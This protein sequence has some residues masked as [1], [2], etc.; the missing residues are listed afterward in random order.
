MKVSVTTYAFFHP[1][2][3]AN[4]A[5][6]AP[7]V[8]FHMDRVNCLSPSVTEPCSGDDAQVDTPTMPPFCASRFA[9][10]PKSKSQ[11]ATIALAPWE[12]S[13]AALVP[14]VTGSLLPWSLTHLI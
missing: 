12:T 6:A 4:S 1:F 11:G 9:G 7:M 5:P 2:P 3:S 8:V 14:T 13:C 10:P